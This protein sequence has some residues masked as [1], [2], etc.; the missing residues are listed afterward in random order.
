MHRALSRLHYYQ[1]NQDIQLTPMTSAK[2]YLNFVKSLYHLN[3]INSSRTYL[4]S[5]FGQGLLQLFISTQNTDTKLPKRLQ[6]YSSMRT[7]QRHGLLMRRKFYR[8]V[9]NAFRM[10]CYRSYFSSNFSI[11]EPSFLGKIIF[12]QFIIFQKF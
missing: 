6:I 4:F 1:L 7:T 2:I 8:Y 12:H 11:N 5:L 3:S 9:K 10:T